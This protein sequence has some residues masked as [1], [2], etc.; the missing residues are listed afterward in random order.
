MVLV[1]Q[2]YLFDDLSNKLSVWPVRFRKRFELLK[3]H[4]WFP[5][6]RQD[7]RSMFRV[8]ASERLFLI[9]QLPDIDSVIYLDTDL[10]FMRPPEEL[11]NQFYQFDSQQLCGMAPN[12]NHY[13]SRKIKVTVCQT[14]HS[15][16]VT[17]LE[18]YFN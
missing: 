15:L 13:N 6:D 2:D 17:E 16:N 5:E 8:C 10:V 9:S 7:F 3:R 12:I 18:N 11:W 14:I 1:D 4:V